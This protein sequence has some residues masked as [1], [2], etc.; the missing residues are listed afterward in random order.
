MTT[1]RLAPEPVVWFGR[2]TAPAPVAAAPGVLTTQ[3][4]GVADAR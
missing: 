3:S 1:P 2:G 4:G